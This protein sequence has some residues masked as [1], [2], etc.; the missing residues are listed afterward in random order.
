MWFY[1]CFT[2]CENNKIASKC[3]ANKELLVLQYVSRINT[4][5]YKNTESEFVICDIFLVFF[6]FS[7]VKIVVVSIP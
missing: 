1:N 4:E 3:V 6:T 5:K 2:D 7:R